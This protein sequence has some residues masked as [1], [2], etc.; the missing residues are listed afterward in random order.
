[1]HW[2]W[3]W[4]GAGTGAA[5]DVAAEELVRLG[6]RTG[7]MMCEG[8]GPATAATEGDN[9]LFRIGTLLQMSNAGQSMEASLVS[10]FDV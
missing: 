4:Q 5:D 3:T 2:G 10:S 6:G 9:L 8:A 1:M 7:C